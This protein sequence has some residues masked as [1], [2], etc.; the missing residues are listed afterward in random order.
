MRCGGLILID[1]VDARSD[2]SKKRNMLVLC[3][4]DRAKKL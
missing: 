2:S 1:A 4:A 3:Q